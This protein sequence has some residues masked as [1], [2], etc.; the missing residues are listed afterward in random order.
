ME[1]VNGE[2]EREE[3]KPKETS[4]GMTRALTIG[5]FKSLILHETRLEYLK[6]TLF[7]LSS[8]NTVKN[9]YKNASLCE[10]GLERAQDCINWTSTRMVLK[11]F[12]RLTF[13]TYDQ[14][15]GFLYMSELDIGLQIPWWFVALMKSKIGLPKTWREIVIK[16]AK[17]IAE[18]GV[19]EK[20]CR[21]NSGW[22]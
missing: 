1:A 11:S 2:V 17:I 3:Q 14:D 9:T 21:L 15:R 18:M 7:P 5:R 12:D 4:Q 19:Q 8:L 20:Y 16:V 22:C 10:K 6:S 13:S